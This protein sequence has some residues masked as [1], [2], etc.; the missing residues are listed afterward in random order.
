M[1]LKI[2]GRNITLEKKVNG[3]EIHVFFLSGCRSEAEVQD[4]DA[5]AKMTGF[6]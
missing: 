6:C 3:L 4:D 2:T 1:M 5:K